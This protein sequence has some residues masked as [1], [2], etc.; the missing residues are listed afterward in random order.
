MAHEFGVPTTDIEWIAIGYLLSFAAVIPAAGWLG[1]RF[2]TKRVFII[3][4][5]IFVAMSLL[6]GVVPVARPARVVPRP[7]GRR[8]RPAHADRVGDAL[9]GLPDGERA[10]AAIGVLSVTVIAPAIGPMLGGMLV[11]EAS[12][13]WIFLINVPD[14]NR[15]GGP[16]DRLAAGDPPRGSRSARPRRT[17]VV[18]GRACRSCS[19]RCRSARRR[20]GSRRPRSTFAFVGAACIAALIV[21]EQRVSRSDPHVPP[22]ARPVVPHDQHRR[23]R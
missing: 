1:D 6:C 19:T 10:K 12:W 5:A 11:D 17:R 15:H 8:R 14:R 20:A 23:R 13:R 16:V 4:L 2:G 22:A 3:A 7:A 21:V 9:P 18:G